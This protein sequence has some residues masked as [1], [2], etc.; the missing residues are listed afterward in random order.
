MQ[1]RSD[2]VSFPLSSLNMLSGVYNTKKA[3]FNLSIDKNTQSSKF[4]QK[5]IEFIFQRSI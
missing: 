1:N 4:L 2:F 3:Y 5:I